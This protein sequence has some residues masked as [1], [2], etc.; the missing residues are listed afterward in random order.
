MELG[1]FLVRGFEFVRV[2]VTVVLV[3]SLGRG[4]V[5][6]LSVRVS[7]RRVTFRSALGSFGSLSTHS[8]MTRCSS[9]FLALSTVM[10][11]IVSL[12]GLELGLERQCC[13]WSRS[14]TAL[15]PPLQIT[16]PFAFASTTS[17]YL[18]L[19]NIHFRINFRVSGLH[20]RF[21][22]FRSDS[23]ASSSDEFGG[24]STPTR[25]HRRR[26]ALHM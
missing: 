19:T 1:L 3:A 17:L 2:A 21:F 24:Y 12:C 18:F 15:E 8:S 5:L 4:R 6:G 13:D 23:T 22:R 7:C 16:Q 25:A 11:F 26:F 9:K 20:V 14:S 10:L